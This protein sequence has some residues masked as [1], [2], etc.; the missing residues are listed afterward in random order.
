MLDAI[1]GFQNFRNEIA[2]KRADAHNDARHQ[3]P[4][5]G[6]R[7]LLY[8][9]SKS[10]IFKPQHGGYRERTLRD[11]YQ[12]LEYPDGS[13][14]RMTKEERESQVTPDGT[15]RFNT[16][17][18]RSPNP[19]PNLMYEYKKYKPHKNG[20][21]V[22]REK[23]EELDRQG[24]LLFPSSADGRIMFK[25]YLDEQPGA[26]IGDVW[27]DIS[28]LR[29]ADRE[30]LGYPTQKP[31]A[32]LERIINASSNP[33]DVVLDPFCGCGT[34]VIAA[35][36]LGRRWIGIDVT[37]LAISLIKYRLQDSF[38]GIEF[39]VKG[40]PADVGLAMMLAE[41][42][43][44]Q[45]QWWALSLVKAK[46]VEGKEKKGADRGIDGVITFVDDHTHAPKRCLVQ[47]KSGHVTSAAMRDLIG[48]LHRENAE[49]ALLITLEPPS[50][51]MRQ[52]AVA[53]GFYE[54]EGWGRQFPKVQIVTIGELLAGKRPELPPA[55]QTFQQAEFIGDPV[56]QPYLLEQ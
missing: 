9:R 18:L 45:F 49:L 2:W 56:L 17:D 26:V 55:R 54:S 7:L 20:W 24:R 22:S 29:G 25:R 30:R 52:E 19:R 39:E 41:A 8:A 47:V 43:P 38:P 6:D 53:A 31:L 35:Q 36:K 37:H 4:V 32:L 44:Y 21:A 33:G 28:Q 10:A 40:E 15:R 5:L 16:G 42:D 1:F 14:R 46:P 48:T 51:P 50:A 27:I 23:M 11:W 3:F 13:V 12:F 34:A